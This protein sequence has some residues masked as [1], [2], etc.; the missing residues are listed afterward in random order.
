D[1]PTDEDSNNYKARPITVLLSPPPDL[2]VTTVTPDATAVAGGTFHV[3][4]MVTN[5]GNSTP[6][7]ASW[8]DSVYLSDSPTLNAPGAHQWFLGDVTHTGAL[9]HGETYTGS[10]P[11]ALGP[12]TSGQYVIVVA[13]NGFD[14]AGGVWEGPY[15]TNN[16]KSAAT[17]VTTAPA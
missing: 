11:F 3:D 6:A 10:Q 16:V 15:T 4:W 7:G 12:A 17:N 9:A 1:A 14:N 13:N 2:E 5:L 8:T